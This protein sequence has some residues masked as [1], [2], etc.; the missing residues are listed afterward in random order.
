MDID[1]ERI[2]KGLY[3]HDVFKYISDPFGFLDVARFAYK[4][5]D[6]NSIKI[7]TVPIKDRLGKTH[8]CSSLQAMDII[9]RFEITSAGDDK[10]QIEL[11]Q[12]LQNKKVFLYSI[13]LYILLI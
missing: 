4:Q 10:A 3:Q 13:N 1:V 8:D 9:T 11:I 7:F 6:P 12:T 5:N 2:W